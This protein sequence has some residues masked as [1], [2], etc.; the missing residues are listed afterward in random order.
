MRAF[1]RNSVPVIIYGM[2]TIKKHLPSSSDIEA[3]EM[4]RSLLRKFETFDVVYGYQ[5]TMGPTSRLPG[6]E[7]DEFVFNT[8]ST[9]DFKIF[10][11]KE[12]INH[13]LNLYGSKEINSIWL[14]Q[15]MFIILPYDRSIKELFSKIVET[16]KTFGMDLTP[17][18]PKRIF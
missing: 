7:G 13:A 17:V 2:V 1:I 15:N 3:V 16:S 18:E 10:T 4:N 6:E 12:L 9:L 11:K 8:R 14:L 5:K